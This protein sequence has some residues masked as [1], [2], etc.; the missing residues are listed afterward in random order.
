MK[1]LDNEAERVTV[2]F[3]TDDESLPNTCTYQGVHTIKTNPIFNNAYNYAVHVVATK[4]IKK[5]KQ[6]RKGD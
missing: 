3:L 1:Q 6:K 5:Q 2:S 4:C